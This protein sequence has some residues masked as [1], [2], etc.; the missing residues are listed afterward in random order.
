MTLGVV[1]CVKVTTTSPATTVQTTG[2]LHST[3]PAIPTTPASS[4]TVLLT[5][6]QTTTICQKHMARVGHVYVSFVKYSVQPFPQTNDVDLTSDTG[7]GISFPSVP[8]KTGVLDENKKP[9]YQITFTFNP[10]G[11]HSLSSIIVNQQ[12]NVNK[13]VVEFFVPSKP[14]QPF[15]SASN[16]PLSYNSTIINSQACIAHFPAQVP[17]PLSGIRISVLSTRDNQ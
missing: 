11:V 6:V 8:N 3:T 7:N 13:F 12:S 17:S 15:T 9:L 1:A 14:K 10:A 5:S 16:I 2:T 4:T